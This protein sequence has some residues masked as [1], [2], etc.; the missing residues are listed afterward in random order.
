MEWNTTLA[1]R[2]EKE[3]KKG[4][5]KKINPPAQRKADQKTRD[6]LLNQKHPPKRKPSR[7]CRMS[8]HLMDPL[9]VAH[10]RRKR[11]HLTFLSL[12]PL[13]LLRSV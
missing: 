5:E 9:P 7:A 11:R 2:K 10:W 12:E 13:S 4:G 1:V 8:S 6:Q 3:K